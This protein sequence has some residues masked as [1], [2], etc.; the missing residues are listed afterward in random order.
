MFVGVRACTGNNR[1]AVVGM[2]LVG[3][4]GCNSSLKKAQTNQLNQNVPVGAVNLCWWCLFS[5]RY[6]REVSL[7]QM[8]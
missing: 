5:S 7:R 3:R 1:G 8:S 4:V 2:L 6:E